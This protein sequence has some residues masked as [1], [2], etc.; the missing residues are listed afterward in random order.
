MSHRDM[1]EVTRIQ[2]LRSEI[3]VPPVIYEAATQ[4]LS[5][6][7]SANQLNENNQEQLMEKSVR[8]ALELAITTEKIIATSGTSKSGL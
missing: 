1:S 5:A 6:Y 4:I 2:Y 3:T 8:L 7:V